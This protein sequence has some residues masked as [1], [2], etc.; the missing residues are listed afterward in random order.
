MRY[1]GI[2]INDEAPAL[3]GWVREKFGGYNAE[4]YKKVFELL[5]RLRANFLWPAMWPGYPN[6]G[7]SFF[8]DDPE[9][10]PM[11]DAW[12]IVVSTSHHEPMQ[13]LS[14]E[15][16]AENPLG[17]WD[18]LTNKEKIT[19]FFAK[20]VERAKGLESYFTLGMRGEYD[21]K[22]RTDDPAA[23]VRDVLRTQRSLVKHT[24]GREDAVPQLLAIYKEVQEQYD[25]GKLE[26]PDDVTLLFSD[27]NFGSIRRLPRGKEVERKGGSGIYYHFE[28]VGTPRSYKWINGNSLGKTWHQLQEAHRR[29]ARQIWV[30]NVGDIKPLEVPLTFAMSLA[31]DINS[32]KADGLAGFLGSIASQ[33]FG[34]DLSR[35]ITHAFH[36]YDRLVSLRRHEHIEPTT[37]SL[38]HYNEADSILSRWESCLALAESI[39]ARCQPEQ[40]P[41]VFQLVL[42]PIKASAIFTSLQVTLGRNQLYARQRHN[43][44]NLLARRALA[45]FD[46]DFDLSAEYHGLLGGKWNQIMCQP[47]TGFGATWH[48]PTRDMLAGLCYVQTRQ[49]SNPIA[50]ALGVMVEGHA[51]VRPGVANENSDFTH[52]SRGDLVPGVTLGSMTRYGPAT[53]WFELFTRGTC[54]VRWTAAASRGWVR[55]AP[56][57]GTLV[58]GEEDR[59][60]RVEVAWDE[61]PPGWDEEVV[62]E[63]R[64]QEGDFE[65]V[66]LPVNGRK[67]PGTFANGFVES[68]GHI[69][70]PPMAHQSISH[71]YRLLADVGRSPSGSLALDATAGTSAPDWLE[72]PFFVFSDP[73]AVCSLTLYF[74]MTLDF[75]PDDL[76]TYEFSIDGGPLHRCRLLDID[77]VQGDPELPSPAEW[78][79]AVQDGVWRKPHDVRSDVGRTG[80]HSLRLRLL[81]ANMILEKI[82]IDFGDL[83][84]SY[85]GPPP[86]YQ[87]RS[88]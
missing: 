79:T 16:L 65:H 56:D 27:D 18:W 39:Y 64:S 84:E 61:V 10:P 19:Q 60:V 11:A 47:H 50:G 38:L 30:F 49:P 87:L 9:N 13:R 43:S 53:R 8:T 58:P 34:P 5:L 40:Q 44:A 83:K 69:S 57:E 55:L 36:E 7:A 46:A 15:W 1:R 42:H 32:I 63:I 74:T 21:T 66:H 14:N 4:F 24:Y 81:H 2:F 54:A 52:P 78:V 85:L 76:M 48:A 88:V 77:A 26:V 31:W 3:T 80:G 28:Y 75:D 12:G 59:R 41:A 62:I 86:S 51:G 17:T 20:G 45:L 68:D 37:F 72:Y 35:D 22:M 6:P 82:V 25:S 73:A 33:W 67:A 29:G 71:S 23:V 70:I